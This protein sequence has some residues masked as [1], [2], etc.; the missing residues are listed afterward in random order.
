MNDVYDFVPL[1]VSQG[2]QKANPVPFIFL[3]TSR[4]IRMKFDGV[5]KQLQFNILI[6][7]DVMNEGE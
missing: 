1:I 5:L 2:Q 7:L 4:L 3:H 6:L